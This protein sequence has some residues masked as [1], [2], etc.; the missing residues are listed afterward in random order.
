MLGHQLQCGSDQNPI[1]IDQGDHIGHRCDRRDGHSHQEK[2][3]M[4]I[5]YLAPIVSQ[6]LTHSPSELECDSRTAQSMERIVGI[7]QV[8]VDDG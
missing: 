5:G 3:T 6:N 1:L 7:G 8:R 4:H 2:V